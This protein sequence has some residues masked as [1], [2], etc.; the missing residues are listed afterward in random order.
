M[1]EEAPTA[2]SPSPATSTNPSPTANTANSHPPNRRNKK[3]RWERDQVLSDIESNRARAREK[4]KLPRQLF[5]RNL[6]HALSVRVLQF[7]CFYLAVS[8]LLYAQDDSSSND[9]GNGGSDSKVAALKEIHPLHILTFSLA[10]FAISA[11]TTCLDYSFFYTLEVSWTG[12]Y[13]VVYYAYSLHGVLG[14][15]LSLVITINLLSPMAVIQ[16]IGSLHTFTT[17]CLVVSLCYSVKEFYLR[18]HHKNL[19]KVR[20]KQKLAQMEEWSQILSKLGV[21]HTTTD[22]D[23]EYDDVEYDEENRVSALLGVERDIHGTMS[24]VT[25]N[26][27]LQGA[28][29]YQRNTVV[30]RSDGSPLLFNSTKDAMSLKQY[31][32]DALGEYNT[33]SKSRDSVDGGGTA[34]KCCR[35]VCCGCGVESSCFSCFNSSVSNNGAPPLGTDDTENASEFE[36]LKHEEKIQQNF[37][38]QVNEL[39]HGYLRVSSG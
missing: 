23:D 10:V 17:S 7:V 34:A 36:E 19:L 32:D 37:W 18:R 33:H 13:D 16:K 29:L 15:V 39:K 4:E 11:T 35:N 5:L 31:R 1:Q 24:N 28:G 26:P 20:L 3:K 27:V 12:H 6:T 25:F 30:G 22:E 14:H 2:E 9:S 38:R 8:L 21:S